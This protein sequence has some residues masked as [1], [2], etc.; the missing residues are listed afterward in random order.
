MTKDPHAASIRR[1][2]NEELDRHYRWASLSGDYC[3]RAQMTD[4]RRAHRVGALYVEVPQ[5]Q[6]NSRE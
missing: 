1:M 2:T 4:L 5:S 3:R 6:S